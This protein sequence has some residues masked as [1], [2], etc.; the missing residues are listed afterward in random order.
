MGLTTRQPPVI[1]PRPTK[2]PQ[3]SLRSLCYSNFKSIHVFHSIMIGYMQKCFFC[4]VENTISLDMQRSPSEWQKQK[5]GGN[6]EM[7]T[8][9]NYKWLIK[10]KLYVKQICFRT[11]FPL[12]INLSNQK[13]KQE[14]KKQGT[15]RR[16]VLRGLG[17]KFHILSL[18]GDISPAAS[19]FLRHTSITIC[20]SLPAAMCSAHW[21]W[22]W[23]WILWQI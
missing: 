14:K 5:H 10:R 4:W 15:W 11:F 12:K 16:M 8:K 7:D 6:K 23:K 19:R 22:H 2:M 9:R 18:P 21:M 13:F 1:A 17:K 3:L 20:L